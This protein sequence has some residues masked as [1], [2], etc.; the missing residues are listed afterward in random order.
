MESVFVEDIPAIEQGTLLQNRWRVIEKLEEGAFGTVFD[1]EEE[2]T[3]QI[4]VAKVEQN[5]ESDLVT[6]YAILDQFDQ[7]T[8]FPKAKAF[9]CTLKQDYLVMEKLGPNLGT[10][11]D[12]H[13]HF[14]ISSV[15]AI[16]FQLIDRIE[17]VH[18]KGLLHLDIKPENILIGLSPERY[19]VIHLIDFGFAMRYREQNESLQSELDASQEHLENK[20]PFVGTTPFASRHRH[21][22]SQFS[23]RDDLESI[24]YILIYLYKGILPWMKKVSHRDDVS[25]RL[26]TAE[27]KERITPEELC[28]GMPSQM[29]DFVYLVRE[30]QYGE[31]PKYD[32]LRQLMVEQLEGTTDPMSVKFE[33]QV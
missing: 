19:N 6:E 2:E 26:A 4:F 30:H 27:E 11:S 8:G 16:G 7:K 5:D 9:G 25:D 21:R 15:A 28:D 29:S 1:V 18:A 17:E 13:I 22:G 32:F 24:A 31:E 3:G 12:D 10:L 33:W 20:I 14:S 23:R